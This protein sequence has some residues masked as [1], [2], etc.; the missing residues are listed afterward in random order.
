MFININ[1]NSWEEVIYFLLTFWSERWNIKSKYLL[2]M[3]TSFKSCS[4]HF[5]IVIYDSRVVLTRSCVRGK[6]YFRNIIYKCRLLSIYKSPTV[7]G[8]SLMSSSIWRKNIIGWLN[9]QWLWISWQSSC[10]R[11][12]RSEVQIKLLAKFNFIM[13]IYTVENTKMRPGTRH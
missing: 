13:D 6:R 12:Q 5:A 7:K 10:F 11:Y 1:I 2:Q 4:T 9:G 3:D 8:N